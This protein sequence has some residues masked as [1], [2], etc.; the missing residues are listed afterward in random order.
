[1]TETPSHPQ[2]VGSSETAKQ[3]EFALSPEQQKVVDTMKQSGE[4]LE[5]TIVDAREKAGEKLQKLHGKELVKA[6]L[7]Q[8]T[9]GAWETFKSRIKWAVG[10]GLVGGAV[11]ALG[12]GGAMLALDRMS[13]LESPGEMMA[14]GGVAGGMVGGLSGVGIGQLIGYETAGVKYNK[15]IAKTEQS[16]ARWY[17]WAAGNLGVF[18][19]RRLLRGK[20]IGKAGRIG[21][22]VFETVFNPIGVSGLRNVAAGLYEMG[23]EKYAK[24]KAKS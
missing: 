17:D 6:G 13:D 12:A 19:L 22:A 7:N 2:F 9:V 10:G 4:K 21:V 8:V 5:K 1:M 11:G 24:F 23:K 18:G 16:K 15:A 3:P 14:L 20:D